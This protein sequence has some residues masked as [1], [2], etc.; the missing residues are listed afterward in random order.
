V[1]EERQAYHGWWLWLEKLVDGYLET[2]TS[3]LERSKD[4]LRDIRSYASLPLIDSLRHIQLTPR[5]S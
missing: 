5:Y 1:S 3:V 4:F 2:D